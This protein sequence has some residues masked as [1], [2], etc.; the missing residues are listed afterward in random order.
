M[1]AIGL[2][3]SLLRDGD[4]EN[5]EGLVSADCIAGLREN[6]RNLK[7]TERG[8][9]AVNPDDIFFTFITDFKFQEKG[10]AI[11]LGTL[12]IQPAP[13]SESR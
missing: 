10:Q 11:R 3:T 12:L 6:L 7:P 9:L 2:V 4:Y 13:R 5:L 1:Q 8:E